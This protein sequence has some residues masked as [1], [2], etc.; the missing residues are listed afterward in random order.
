M[1]E[2][3]LFDGPSTPGRIAAGT[4]GHRARMRGRL[5]ANGPAALADVELL[6]MVLFLALPRRDTM[7]I[8]GALLDRFGSF[9]AAVAAPV[10]QLRGV[11]G[12]GEAGA[13]ALKTIEAAVLR[14][15]RPEPS[16]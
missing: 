5:L 8:A 2:N 3:D 11:E 1:A 9:A 10:N 15:A 7:P 14:L 4:E 13:A 6:E 12:L 16:S